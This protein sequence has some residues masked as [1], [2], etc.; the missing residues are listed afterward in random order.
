MGS[1]ICDCKQ[2]TF[3]AASKKVISDYTVMSVRLHRDSR[4]MRMG[5][6]APQPRKWPAIAC[7]MAANGLIEEEA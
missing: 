4:C 5:N 3:V 6:D 7:G 1:E 2:G